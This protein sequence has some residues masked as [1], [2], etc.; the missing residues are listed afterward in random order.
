MTNL[1]VERSFTLPSEQR[2]L[3]ALIKYIMNNVV[4][5]YVEVGIR[6]Y[7]S[8]ITDWCNIDHVREEILHHHRTD[9]PH[10][11]NK[12]FGDEDDDW[13]EHKTRIGDPSQVKMNFFVY[14]DFDADFDG[15][16][17]AE[18]LVSNLHQ[19]ILDNNRDLT[20]IKLNN[21]LSLSFRR[22]ENYNYDHRGSD[23]FG[24]LLPFKHDVT[25]KPDS[26]LYDLVNAIF[27]TRSHKTDTQYEMFTH[28]TSVIIPSTVI[29]TMIYD[30]GS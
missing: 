22:D 16:E 17:E 28:C 12:Y 25:V 23:H 29:I 30:N 7:V 10:S 19:M 9:I 11:C 5:E 26:T 18:E 20:A 21:D 27:L 4:I 13:C 15:D 14:P 6:M 1:A 24:V 3:T 8:A 2:L